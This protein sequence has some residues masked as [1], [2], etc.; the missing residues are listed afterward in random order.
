M[1]ELSPLHFS[2]FQSLGEEFLD[3]CVHLVVC[4]DAG[5]RILIGCVDDGSFSVH[6]CSVMIDQIILTHSVDFWR[7]QMCGIGASVSLVALLIHSSDL[8]SKCPKQL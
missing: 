5:F 4:M 8:I 6:W 7:T 3:L 2:M 1:S